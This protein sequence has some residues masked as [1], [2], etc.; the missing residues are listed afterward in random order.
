MPTD[1]HTHTSSVFN[2]T[3]INVRVWRRVEELRS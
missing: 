1:I 2:S 3:F